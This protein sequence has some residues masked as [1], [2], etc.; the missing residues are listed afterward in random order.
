MNWFFDL[1]EIEF[2]QYFDLLDG[3]FGIES[4]VEICCDLYI[5]VG[6]FMDCV[7]D[8]DIYGWIRMFCFNFEGFE[9]V[10]Q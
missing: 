6:S 3:F 5:F 8:V 9:V 2:I 7:Y 10:G 4:L 1:G